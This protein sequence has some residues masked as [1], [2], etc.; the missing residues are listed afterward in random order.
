M[1]LHLQ[2]KK[3]ESWRTTLMISIRNN[4]FETNSSSTHSI[5]IPKNCTEYIKFV[6]FRFED[7]GWAF[8]HADPANYLYTAICEIY[9]DTEDYKE[10]TEALDKLKSVLN[11]YK[12]EYRFEPIVT[13][14][15]S[16]NPN[17]SYEDIG[18]IDHSAELYGMLNEL[19]NDE[20]LLMRYLTVGEVYTGNDNGD[21]SEVWTDDEG[22]EHPV[23]DYAWYEPDKENYTYFYKGN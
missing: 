14:N 6:Y 2:I 13:R 16:W 8:T 1:H 15:A 3:Q 21:S 22:V 5:C 19:L 17:Y 18:S 12:V 9:Q 10:R 23:C 11:K 4:T 7:F 20:E